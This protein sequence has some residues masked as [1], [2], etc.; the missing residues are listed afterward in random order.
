[1]KLSEDLSLVQPAPVAC[2]PRALCCVPSSVGF[3]VGRFQKRAQGL[4]RACAL[5]LGLVPNL[6][7]RGVG[8]S[9]PS[10]AEQEQPA[11]GC[12]VLLTGNKIPR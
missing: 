2:I 10:P 1:M 12:S 7:N 8:C 6:S 3:G 11:L 9:G 4:E 5:R